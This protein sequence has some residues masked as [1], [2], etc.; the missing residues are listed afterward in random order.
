MKQPEINFKIQ[1]MEKIK[2]VLSKPDTFNYVSWYARTNSH[3]YNIKYDWSVEC[4][5]VPDK[6]DFYKLDKPNEVEVIVEQKETEWIEVDDYY[7]PNH[8]NT[9]MRQ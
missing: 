6:Y 5:Y 2:S 9:T 8:S 1:I 7:L 3:N 4:D